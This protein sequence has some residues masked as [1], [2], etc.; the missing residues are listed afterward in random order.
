V[1]GIEAALKAGK[2]V[3]CDRYAHSGAAYT[4]SKGGFSLEWCK[5]PDSG[6]P[7]PDVVLFLDLAPEA[8]AQRA[9]FGGERYERSDFQKKI[10]GNFADLRASDG[11]EVRWETVDADG[12]VDDVR[13]RVLAKARPAVA[14]A[15]AGK[16]LER[17]WPLR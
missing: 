13:A 2:H 3:V 1:A 14:E 9:D 12:S 15:E 8:A 16:E 6:L 11:A 4:G 7:K 5:A 17:L 10:Y